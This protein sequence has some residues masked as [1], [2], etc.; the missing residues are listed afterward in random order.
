M[1]CPDPQALAQWP[2]ELTILVPSQTWLA[3]IQ[4]AARTPVKVAVLNPATKR[5]T[6]LRIGPQ[7]PDPTAPRG[8]LCGE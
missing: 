1:V 3:R 4:A 7:P 5:C 8:L 6:F 2:P